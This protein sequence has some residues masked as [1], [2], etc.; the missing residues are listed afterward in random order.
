MTNQESHS[1][2]TQLFDIG[3]KS[4]NSFNDKQ[5]TLYL[6][7]DIFNYIDE[8]ELDVYLSN[9]LYPPFDIRPNI[10]AMRELGLHQIADK[11]AFIKNCFDGHSPHQ[12]GETWDQYKLRIG[13]WSHVDIWDKTLR[14]EFNDNFPYAWID[15]NYFELTDGLNLSN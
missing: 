9:N 14:D 7:L 13:I 3:L 6:F 4:T 2:C 8:D 10:I 1:L 12:Q 5:K 15:Q 11:F